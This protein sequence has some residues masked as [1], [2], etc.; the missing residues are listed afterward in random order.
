MYSI[1]KTVSYV[2]T[3]IKEP[4][5]YEI[6]YQKKKLKSPYKER[7]V[8]WGSE[9]NSQINHKVFSILQTSTERM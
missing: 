6:Q 2:F 4:R 7:K 1:E 8:A 3:A 9:N 5:L